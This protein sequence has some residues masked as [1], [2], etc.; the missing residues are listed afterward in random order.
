MANPTYPLDRRVLEILVNRFNMKKDFDFNAE[1]IA[2]PDAYRRFSN[3]IADAAWE[4]YSN[5]NDREQR[6]E[7]YDPLEVITWKRV[8]GQIESDSSCGARTLKQIAHAL[9]YDNWTILMQC[10]DA[11]YADLEDGGYREETKIVKV[12]ALVENLRVDDELDVVWVK[13]DESEAKIQLTYLGRNRFRVNAKQNCS[14]EP[15]DE[16]VAQRFTMDRP[17]CVEDVRRGNT[18]LGTY[19]GVGR[20]TRVTPIRKERE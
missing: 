17:V 4:Y 14:F 10:L 3:V 11:E 16:F 2:T 15:G 20:I 18:Y 5:G 8:F 9:E 1:V 13:G 7:D 19:H 12:D 6:P